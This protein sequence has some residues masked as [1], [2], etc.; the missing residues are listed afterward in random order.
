MMKRFLIVAIIFTSMIL[1]AHEVSFIYSVIENDLSNQTIE[2]GWNLNF[3]AL[4]WG[5][6][7]F[8]NY[9]LSISVSNLTQNYTK[10]EIDQAWLRFPVYKDLNLRVGKQVLDFSAGG[11]SGSC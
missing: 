5:N 1:Q 7:D 10:V 9:A 11:K 6:N 2:K 3:A 8:S 4:R